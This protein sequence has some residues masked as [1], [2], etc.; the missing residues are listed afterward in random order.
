VR[1]F[2][3]EVDIRVF[4]AVEE[5]LPEFLADEGGRLDASLLDTRT[6]KSAIGFGLRRAVGM[7]P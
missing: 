7:S 1:A 2:V 3:G 5:I 6:M 4:N